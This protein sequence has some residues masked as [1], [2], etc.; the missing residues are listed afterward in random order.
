MITKESLQARKD[1]LIKEKDLMEQN[2]TK[3]QNAINASQGR[4]AQ[5]RD[6]LLAYTGAIQ[7]VDY[8]LSQ[9]DQPAEEPKE[10]E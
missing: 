5:L 4:C 8:W 7:D 2:L 9:T 3:E 10:G 6:N 1:I